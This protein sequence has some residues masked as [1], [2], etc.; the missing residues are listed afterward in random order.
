M[1][2]AIHID[3]DFKM[4]NTSMSKQQLIDKKVIR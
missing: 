4:N 2:T 1:C 3:V